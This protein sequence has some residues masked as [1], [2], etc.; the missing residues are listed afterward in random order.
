MWVGTWGPGALGLHI[1]GAAT[2]RL[3]VLPGI[4]TYM[5]KPKW[6][7]PQPE[8][9]QRSQPPA[10]HVFPATIPKASHP[11]S[12]LSKRR[13][14]EPISTIKWWVF[15]GTESWGGGYTAADDQIGSVVTSVEKLR[16]R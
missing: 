6:G 7:G 3:P 15:S 14:K 1:G 12:A 10:V 13:P 16:H 2:P 8:H 11:L 5:G 9:P 4:S